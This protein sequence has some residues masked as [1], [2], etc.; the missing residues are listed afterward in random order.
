MRWRW[1][2]QT[3]SSP[4]L[5]NMNGTKSDIDPATELVEEDED[6]ALP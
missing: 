2:A 4:Y 5:R 3:V 6:Q 1:V